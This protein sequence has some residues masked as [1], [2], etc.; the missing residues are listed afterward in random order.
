MLTSTQTGYSQSE[1]AAMMVQA[2]EVFWSIVLSQRTIP[3]AADATL[4]T[5]KCVA[6]SCAQDSEQN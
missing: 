5:I 2:G 3:N 1:D 6:P 4:S